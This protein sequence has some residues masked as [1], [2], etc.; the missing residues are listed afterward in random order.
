MRPSSVQQSQLINMTNKF[1]R[2]IKVGIVLPEDEI[3]TV[4]IRFT[5]PSLFEIET[6]DKIDPTCKTPELL[7]IPADTEEMYIKRLDDKLDDHSILIKGVPAGRGFHWQKTIDVF[8]PGSLRIKS[9]DRTLLIINEVPLEHYLTSVA[10]SEMS[11]E[12]PSAFLEAQ[13]I[14][15]RSWVLAN[16]GNKH[17]ELGIDVC[18]DDCCQRYQGVSGMTE[19]AVLASN[20]SAG[21]VLKY[22]NEICD[23]RYSKS[24]GGTTE[25]GSNV[26][27]E[28]NLDYLVSVLDGDPPNC[29]PDY[30]SDTD[31]PEYLGSVDEDQSYFRWTF[32]I[33][34]ERLNQHINTLYSL[35]AR[36]VTGI[37]NEKRGLSD[38]ILSCD[39]MFVDSAGETNSKQLITEYEIRNALSP[40]FLFS[41]A[42][43][44]KPTGKNLTVPEKFLYTGKGWGH[45]AGM[46]QIGALG[47]ALNGHT[48]DSILNHYYPRAK[49]GTI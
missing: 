31:L 1:S 30:I 35:N 18:N 34:Q 11:A 32:E 42:F 17:S 14:A 9:V 3:G 39:L 25:N 45:G 46:C 26:W 4:H 16:I 21:K 5:D 29:G 6:A 47:K 44:M 36:A 48:T 2:L 23:A 15:A 27:P 40:T 8:L 49:L 19:H 41:S 43:T 24:C 13:M 12:C 37:E 20:K 10:V 28:E 38:R 22:G 7:D 33:S